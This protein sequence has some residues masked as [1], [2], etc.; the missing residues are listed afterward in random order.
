M[1]PYVKRVK[2]DKTEEKSVQI[3]IIYEKNFSLIYWE[4]EWLVG[5]DPFYLKFWVNHP[6]WSEIAD[7]EPII[8]RSASAIT[9]SE[10]TSINANRKSPTRFPVSL[11][12]SSYVAPKLPKGRL[13]N[14]KW[15]FFV[16]NRTSLEK[17]SINTN[18]KSST[19]FP[20]SQRWT[21]MSSLRPPK[22]KCPI[23][24][25]LGAITPKRY[26]IGCQLLLITNRS[27]IRAF[28]WYRPRWPSMTLNGVIALIS[29][30][31]HLIRLLCWPIISTVQWIW[32]ETYS[33][34][35]KS[36]PLKLIAIFSLRLSIFPWWLVV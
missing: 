33:V 14:A 1:R 34:S 7:L 8:A 21:C 16:L 24:E 23:F 2:C 18:K 25:Q 10:K 32:R 19:R 36:S 27:R 29:R 17:S 9:P 3:C 26:E 4:K 12:W 11:R 31:F 35:Q 5:A 20:I 13:K 6:R 30:F 15:P 22:W 28:D